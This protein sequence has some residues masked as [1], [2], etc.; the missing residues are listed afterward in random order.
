MREI[1]IRKRVYEVGTYDVYVLVCNLINEAP[2]SEKESK[3]WKVHWDRIKRARGDK[4]RSCG[5]TAGHAP[6]CKFDLANLE[7]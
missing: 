4:C 1:V 5:N 3:D 7:P 2:L 6:N